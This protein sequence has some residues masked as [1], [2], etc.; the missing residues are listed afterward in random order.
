MMIFEKGEQIGKC[1]FIS[2]HSNPASP[3]LW[4]FRSEAT[5]NVYD[6]RNIDKRVRPPHSATD[7]HQV[8]GRESENQLR[9]EIQIIFCISRFDWNFGTTKQLFAFRSREMN[10][11]IDSLIPWFPPQHS[12]YCYEIYLV[13][14]LL[15]WF[16]F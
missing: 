12:S 7:D 14:L 6:L 4:H 10:E 3:H 11:P 13:L 15:L 8:H 5:F 2:N 16:S 9:S 1:Y